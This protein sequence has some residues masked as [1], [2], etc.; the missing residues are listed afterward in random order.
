M[1]KYNIQ[2]YVRYKADVK[3]SVARVEGKFFDEYSRDELII[4]FLPLVENLAR[5]FSTSDQASGILSIND[6]IQE[7]S[8]ALTLAVDKIDWEKLHESPDIEK[9]LKSFISKRI[10]GAI[11]RAININRGTMR[12]PE[13]VL[14]DMRNNPSDN[15]VALFFNSIFLSADELHSFNNNE[16]YATSWLENIPDKSETYNI[17]ILNS[18]LMGL[19]KQHLNFKQQEVLRLSYGLDCDKMS[20]P[21]IAKI[22]NVGS[23]R[24]SQIKKE[25]INALIANTDEAQ[26]IDYL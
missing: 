5:K 26:V 9:T 19:I 18:Y 14:N 6:L 13:H 8:M 22:L 25:A 3:Q 15:K 16:E 11:R 23:V 24:V 12:I 4:K 21:E 20:G 10:K 1:K 17:D 7:G 2:N